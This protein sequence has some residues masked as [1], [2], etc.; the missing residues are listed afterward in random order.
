MV[1]SLKQAG[2]RGV[3]ATPE[4]IHLD[5]QAWGRRGAN[6][7]ELFETSKPTLSDTHP[8]TK[9]H[10]LVLLILLK[11]HSLTKHSIIWVCEGHSYSNHN[12]GTADY[13]GHPPYINSPLYDSPWHPIRS[14]SQQ[15]QVHV[16]PCYDT[17]AVLIFMLR[18]EINLFVSICSYCCCLVLVLWC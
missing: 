10:L 5:P 14:P 7:C 17:D 15:D 9:P 8:P 13:V 18:T 11:V 16:A 6:W 12:K 3:G 4:R 1:E 2:R